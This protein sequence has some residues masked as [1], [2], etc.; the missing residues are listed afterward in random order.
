[1]GPQDHI[2]GTPFA[3]VFGLTYN[4]IPFMTLPLFASLDRLDKRLIEAGND[5]LRQQRRARSGR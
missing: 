3:V 4:F 1:M 2:T 5:L